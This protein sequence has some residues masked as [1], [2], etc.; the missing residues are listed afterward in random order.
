MN[1]ERYI[2][3]TLKKL[4]KIIEAFYQILAGSSFTKNSNGEHEVIHSHK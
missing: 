2:T 1:L 4:A 3:S